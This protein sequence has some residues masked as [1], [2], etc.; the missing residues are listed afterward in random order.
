[1]SR[2]HRYAVSGPRCARRARRDARRERAQRRG[3]AV[4]RGAA[5]EEHQRRLQVFLRLASR[6][7]GGARGRG[8]H[9]REVRA[10]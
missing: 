7:A 3:E 5:R 1:M 6:P 2:M 10:A 9:H 8:A 4:H